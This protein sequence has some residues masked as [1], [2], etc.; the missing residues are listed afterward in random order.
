MVSYVKLIGLLAL[1]SL[2][3]C[4][5]QKMEKLVGD[6][7]IQF[8]IYSGNCSGKCQIF[9]LL[10]ENEVFKDELYL[11][12]VIDKK[13]YVGRYRV[14]SNELFENVKQLKANFPMEILEENKSVFGYPDAHDQGGI[15][16]EYRKGESH[17]FW[18]IDPV[19]ERVPEYLH[20]YLNQL[21]SAHSILNK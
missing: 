5:K 17:K 19:K 14:L 2:G 11:F 9:Y 10:T 21:D 1:L 16:L 15:Y 20:S 8:G 7:Y 13:P 4:E 6:D 18:H 3:N 12:S